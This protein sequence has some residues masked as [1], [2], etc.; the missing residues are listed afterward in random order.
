MVANG[1][2]DEIYKIINPDKSFVQFS[3]DA[4]TG[5]RIQINDNQNTTAFTYNDMGR[6][7]SVTPAVGLPTTLQYDAINGVD[8]EHIERQG[9][10]TKNIT[11]NAYHRVTRIEDEEGNVYGP[12][13]YDG[14][15]RID[16]VTETFD[17]LNVATD[18][19]FYEAGVQGAYPLKE[20][21]KDGMVIASY[22]L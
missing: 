17:G 7:I 20:I 9:M 16:T 14:F 13:T 3:Y 21:K 15:G 4:V 22:N 5:D 8:L 12:I 11:Y 2:R 6:V 1:Q 19:D 10:G 18:Y